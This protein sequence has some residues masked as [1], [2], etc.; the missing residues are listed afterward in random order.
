MWNYCYHKLLSFSEM[1]IWMVATL[2]NFLDKFLVILVWFLAWNLNI[3]DQSW[4]VNNFIFLHWVTVTLNSV[5]YALIVSFWWEWFLDGKHAS[6]YSK[7]YQINLLLMLNA[8]VSCTKQLSSI[9]SYVSTANHLER[10]NLTLLRQTCCQIWFIRICMWSYLWK[11]ILKLNLVLNL[12]QV[13]TT[14]K[15]ASKAFHL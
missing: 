10:Y 6:I 8:D 11:I 5:Y 15:T 13:F 3:L 9:E 4:A 12:Q 14:F 1:L 7:F 2:C